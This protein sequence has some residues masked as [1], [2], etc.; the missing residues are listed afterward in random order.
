MET[1]AP[2]PKRGLRRPRRSTRCCR[3]RNHSA[4]RSVE[5]D[6]S[7]AGTRL[8]IAERFPP[9]YIQLP[10]PAIPVTLAPV[11]LSPI[12]LAPL[13]FAP[14]VL[15]PVALLVPFPIA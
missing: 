11:A 8:I 1:S 4:I 7:A 13:M 9:A 10:T 12:V 15:A 6:Y 5:N 2:Q 14:A 3:R